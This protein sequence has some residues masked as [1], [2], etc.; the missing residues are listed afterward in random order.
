MKK[1]LL[2]MLICPDCLPEENRL[3]VKIIQEQSEDIINGHLICHKCGKLYPIRNGTAFLKPETFQI[4]KHDENKYETAPALSSY[5]WSHYSDILEEENAC[6]A[7]CKWAN[8]MKSIPGVTID[9]GCAAGR[10]T[11]EMSKKS[12]FAVGID[13][14]YSFVQSARELMI[15]RRMK[16][17][18]KQEGFIARKTTLILPET[19]NSNKVEFIVGDAQALPFRS[20]II[21]SFASLNLIDKVPS[22]IKHLNEMNRVTKTKDAQFLLSDPF[23]WSTDVANKEDWLGG[24]NN[25]SYAG[26]GIENIIALLKGHKNK[27]LPEWSIEQRGN[28]WWKIRTHSNHFELIRSCFVKAER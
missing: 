21:S 8:F 15:K 23:S 3:D 22:P 2:D 20:K 25:G 1:V 5:M 11:F 16:I 13:S 19:W 6:D 12:D 17:T 27:L 9:A 28:V 18:L 4:N 14:S 24:K 26:S 10:F 7:Y